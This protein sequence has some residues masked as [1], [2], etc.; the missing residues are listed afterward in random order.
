MRVRDTVQNGPRRELRTNGE[1][2]EGEGSAGGARGCC[3][4]EGTRDSWLPE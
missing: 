2:R 4:E 1:V 3:L